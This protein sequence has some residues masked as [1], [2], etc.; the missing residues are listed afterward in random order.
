MTFNGAYHTLSYH[1][2]TPHLFPDAFAIAITLK[3]CEI[4]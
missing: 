1:I 2:L 4:D 3:L